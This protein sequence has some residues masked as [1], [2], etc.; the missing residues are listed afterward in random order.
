AEALTRIGDR[1]SVLIGRCLPYG[2]GIT[3]W[4]M[5]EA[6]KQAAG[7]ADGDSAEHVRSKVA[8]LLDGGDEDPLVAERIAQV[9]GVADSAAT[10]DET[11]W[12]LRKLL[13]GIAS[14]RP[15]VLLLEDAHWAEPTLLDLIEYLADWSRNV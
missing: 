4:P 9:I 8:A 12:A 6:V 5:V 2:E 1:A 14:T 11:F 13:E 15:L 3:Y 7:I 10:S